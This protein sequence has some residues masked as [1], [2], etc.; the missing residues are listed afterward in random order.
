M[1][2]I[3]YKKYYPGASVTVHYAEVVLPRGMIIQKHERRVYIN[4][5][6]KWTFITAIMGWETAL[7][8]LRKDIHHKIDHDTKAW[9]HVD[10]PF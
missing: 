5:D 3:D 1:N 6:D 7:E 8:E 9:P 2:D 10:S 4:P